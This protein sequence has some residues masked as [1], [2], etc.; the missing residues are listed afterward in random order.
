M[1]TGVPLDRVGADD[2]ACKLLL[3]RLL[4]LLELLEELEEP[5]SSEERLLEEPESSEE[6]WSPDE[7][8]LELVAACEEPGSMT[9]T[10]PA[11]ARL[12]VETAAVVVFSR[13]R[14]RARSAAPRETANMPS[15]IS[16]VF[17]RGS[18]PRQLVWAIRPGYEVAMSLPPRPARTRAIMAR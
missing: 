1:L 7:L 2:G 12:A 8:E 9:I 5:E 14:P 4:E 15:R 16:G 11:A 10:T 13:R 6:R 17:M 3:L 18:L